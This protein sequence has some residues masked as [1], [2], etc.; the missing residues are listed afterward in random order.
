MAR[1]FVRSW[2]IDL[3]H[4]CGHVGVYTGQSTADGQVGKKDVK[5]IAEVK[6]ISQVPHIG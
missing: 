1:L 4:I 3:S 6:F 2:W 5:D